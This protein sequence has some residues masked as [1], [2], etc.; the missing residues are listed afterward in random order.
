[1]RLFHRHFVNVIGNYNKF[2]SI[3]SDFS[4]AHSQ[5]DYNNKLSQRCFILQYINMEKAEAECRRRTKVITLNNFCDKWYRTQTLGFLFP[6]LSLSSGFHVLS[7]NISAEAKGK[8][9]APESDSLNMCKDQ[10]RI[11]S[12]EKRTWEYLWVSVLMAGMI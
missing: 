2:Q 12:W 1:M 7:D 3:I 5:S 11:D 6:Y 9:K 10:E 8:A 4:N